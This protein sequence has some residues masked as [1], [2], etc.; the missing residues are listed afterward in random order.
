MQNIEQIILDLAF[1]NLQIINIGD[2]HM[3]K[4]PEE[5]IYTTLKINGP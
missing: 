1:L 4:L 3:N 5:L 2:Y